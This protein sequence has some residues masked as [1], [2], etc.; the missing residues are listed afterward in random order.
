MQSFVKIGFAQISLAAMPKISELPKIW[1]GGGFVAAPQPQWH[2]RLWVLSPFFSFKHIIDSFQFHVSETGL[3][4]VVKK[5][6]QTDYEHENLAHHFM[7][8]L[9]KKCSVSKVYTIQAPVVRRSDNAIH[10][11]KIY[12][13][14]NAI[15]FAITY[16]LESDL[17]VG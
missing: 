1:G 4:F 8:R 2:V 5:Q 13:V 10:W 15:H 7:I 14:D 9:D 12:P 17:T 11:I 3:Q 6:K 16:P